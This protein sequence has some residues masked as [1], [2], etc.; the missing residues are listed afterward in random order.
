M[1]SDV[2]VRDSKNPDS[3]ALMFEAGVWAGFL[4]GVKAGQFD[5]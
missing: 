1:P 3:G 5:L 4:A 2:A